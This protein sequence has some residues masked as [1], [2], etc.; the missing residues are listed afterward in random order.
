MAKYVFDIESDGLLANV[1]TMHLLVCKNVETKE[2]K[3]YLDGD[4]SWIELFN[5]AE[6]VIGQ[7]IIAYDL[8]VLKKLFNYDLPDHTK[9]FDTLL[10]SQILN[11]NRFPNTR[12]NLETWG[13]YFGYPKLEFDDWSKYSEE[14]LEYCIRDVELT[15]KVYRQLD[16]E[17]QQYIGY[18]PKI[19]YYI[20]AEHYAA[21]WCAVAELEGFP[22]DI[23][24]AKA[25]FQT[26]ENEMEKAYLA[27][28]SILGRRAVAV[29][30]VKGEVAEKMPKWIKKGCYDSHTA[31][32]FDIDP[33]S[34]FE[35]EERLVEGPYCR[36][37]FRELSIN[38]SADMKLFLFRHGWEPTEFNTTIDKET[39]K[40][41]QSSPKITEESL[42]FLGGNGKL[43]FDFMTV[44]SRYGILKSWIENTDENGRLHGSVMLIGTPSMRAR[45][46]VIVNV[47]SV[48]S[49]YGKEMR[50]LFHSSNWTFIGAD[51][52]GNQARGLAHFLKDPV[53]IKTLLEGDIHQYNADA[54]TA[55]LQEMGVNHTVPRG[56]AKR[57]LYAFLFGASGQKLWS[58]VFGK[59]DSKQGSKL[60]KGFTSAVPGFEA[61]ITKLNDMYRKTSAKGDG[62][63][64]SI[65]GCK[66]YC[67]SPHKLLV[68]LLQATEKITC[69]T[70][71]MLTMQELKKAKI[72]YQPLVYY[73][74][75]IDFMVPPQYAEQAAAIAA[76]AFKEG[77][78]MYGITIMDG[79]AKIG[80]NWAECH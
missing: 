60:K 14:M 70:A 4:L 11:Y 20:E 68:Y 30:M 40:K 73:H 55:V 31:R 29:D 74:D 66:L 3:H 27:L 61:L 57:I 78:E 50:E 6:E 17:Y 76:K 19:Q 72:P 62:Y 47:P 42:E 9:V 37:E 8:L 24:K 45:H 43:Y 49:P 65:A 53:Y 63:I 1:T 39:G 26:L 54:L 33:W 10:Y 32:W 77:P 28:D 75:E 59:L 22:F 51:S 16:K 25:L 5:N 38:S 23:V 41:K 34:G 69:S 18:N 67:D 52:A 2:L 15:D 13:F 36:V 46:N 58:Y 35:G 21:K 48:D 56:V 80:K 64:P 79:T 7:N 12:H 71:L 44:K